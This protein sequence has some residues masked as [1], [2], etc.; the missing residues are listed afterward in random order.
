MLFPLTAMS[1]EITEHKWGLFPS[2]GGFKLLSKGQWC[3]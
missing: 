3:S 2:V 1:P